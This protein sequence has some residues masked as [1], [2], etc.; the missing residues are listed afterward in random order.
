MSRW[1]ISGGLLVPNPRFIH[2]GDYF[3]DYQ[4]STEENIP[5]HWTTESDSAS[6]ILV[7][8]ADGF[9]DGRC[10]RVEIIDPSTTSTCRL[11]SG[12]TP[13]GSFPFF[14]AGT[15]E[16]YKYTGPNL[17]ASF[18]YKHGSNIGGLPVDQTK[19]SGRLTIYNED[20]SESAPVNSSAGSAITNV[21]VDWTR[22]DLIFP[23]GSFATGFKPDHLTLAIVW[24]S[25]DESYTFPHHIDHIDDIVLRYSL[26][27]SKDITA[28][29][30]ETYDLMD[31]EAHVT[32]YS[33]MM[34]LPGDFVATDLGQVRY[35]DSTGGAIRARMKVHFPALT[36]SDV[37]LLR[38]A[39]LLHGGGY[40]AARETA[41]S[42][43]RLVPAPLVASSPL[44]IEPRPDDVVAGLS[45]VLPTGK[46]PPFFFAWLVD[47]SDVEPV[48]PS[49]W[50]ASATFLEVG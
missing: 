35:S 31:S 47:L 1:R 26:A 5:D 29:F 48:S 10:V 45:G 33:P 13:A 22:G 36:A 25:R 37:A 2:D 12:R 6:D 46:F 49:R 39:R 17:S 30:D 23:I 8:L 21:A 3:Y 20:E 43:P 15:L 40:C 44:V 50:Q 32:G 27:K 41:F 4:E 38:L 42:D 14:H 7:D 11:V 9:S 28:N 19:I 24:T 18:M 16:G 34:D